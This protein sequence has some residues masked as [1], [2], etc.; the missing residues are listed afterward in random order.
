ME[1][2]HTR[3]ESRCKKPNFASGRAGPFEDGQSPRNIFE[4][5]S[6][7]VAFKCGRP[8][9]FTYIV[10]GRAGELSGERA[11]VCEAE[12]SKFRSY[13]GKIWKIIRTWNTRVIIRRQIGIT[14]DDGCRDVTV[15]LN[16]QTG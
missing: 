1:L 10:F 8:L 5:V 9:R 13:N 15:L 4:Y 2:I 11:K 14:N 3:Q 16:V 7:Q 6:K 12:F